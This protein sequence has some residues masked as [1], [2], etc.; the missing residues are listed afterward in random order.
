MS[1]R[2]ERDLSPRRRRTSRTR[3]ARRFEQVNALD[4]PSPRN[5]TKV[6]TP[7]IGADA[8]RVETPVERVQQV[9]HGAAVGGRDDGAAKLRFCGV[10][11]RGIAALAAAGN[12]VLVATRR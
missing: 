9:A 10:G 6:R 3:W 1:G 12:A 11:G 8:G 2:V 5:V 4:H 7:S